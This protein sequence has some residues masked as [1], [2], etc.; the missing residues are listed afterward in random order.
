MF[1]TQGLT[2]SRLIRTRFGKLELP[3]RLSRGKMME[4]TSDQVRSVMLH[5]GMKEEAGD[6]PAAPLPSR[7]QEARNREGG[8]KGPREGGRG[9]NRNNNNRGGN[10]EP[11]RPPRLPADG[12]T[13]ESAPF[14]GEH[15]DH[16]MGPRDP[17][18][19]PTPGPDKNRQR[20]NR[21]GGKNRRG[22]TAIGAGGTQTLPPRNFIPNTQ[23]DGDGHQA[24]FIHDGG[25]Q[26]GGMSDASGNQSDKPRGE[27]AP[28]SNPRNRP[29]R[30]F[31]GRG[32]RNRPPTA[33]EGSGSGG[34]FGPSDAGDN[35]GNL[36]NS[37]TGNQNRTDKGGNFGGD[38]GGGSE[39]NGNS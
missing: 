18:A 21:R 28:G 15:V 25:E 24:P 19:V 1:E 23:F 16:L 8:R 7:Q 31:R 36:G 12:E 14:D 29:R 11:N 22:P 6:G 13:T 27:R 9:D 17:N 2:V 37:G 39:P 34:N 5:A 35:A 20:R 33:N 30:N 3:P 26:G 38:D 4:L 32:G 10:R